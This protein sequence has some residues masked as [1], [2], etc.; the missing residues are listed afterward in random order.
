MAK[1]TKGSP[2]KSGKTSKAKIKKAGKAVS[3]KLLESARGGVVTRSPVARF[4]Y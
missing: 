1:Q 4:K 2:K 3:D